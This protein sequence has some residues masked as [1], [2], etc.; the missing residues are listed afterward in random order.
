MVSIQDQIA[1]V[2]GAGRGIGRAIAVE[3]GKLGA[4]VVLAARSRAELE[5]TAGII[6]PAGPAPGVMPTDV[7][8]KDE[9]ERLFEHAGAVDIL[10]NAAG[11]GIFGPVAGF[12]DEDFDV[13]IETNLRGIFLASRCVLPSMIERKKGHIINIASIAGKVGSANRAVYC[14]SKFGV[15]GFTESLA[16]E[17]RQHGI[18]VSL[19]CPGST[20]TGFSPA[21]T[22]GK[23]RERMLRP[24]DVAHAVRAI[25]TQEPNSFISEIVIRPAQKP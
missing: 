9:I 2:T 1:V 21:E 20:D 24:E 7:R 15:V 10:V 19:I 6:G 18:R 14:A 13:L 3:L 17:V 5:E 16:E 23:A 4:R 11:L 12:K 25:V 22:S 8:K